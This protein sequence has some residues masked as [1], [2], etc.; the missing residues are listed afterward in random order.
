MEI[1][2]I[3]KV[4]NLIFHFYTLFTTLVLYIML[5]QAIFLTNIS[6]N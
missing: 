5:I 2:I 4:F 6:N 3:Q 1:V